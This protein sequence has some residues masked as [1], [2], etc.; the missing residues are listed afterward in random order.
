MADTALEVTLTQ[1]RIFLLCTQLSSEFGGRKLMT[2]WV[3]S[4]KVQDIGHL[5]LSG[6]ALGAAR[7]TTSVAVP[8]KD[9]L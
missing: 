5:V 3:D 7:N 1:L 2:S 4:R 9:R 6:V 8:R